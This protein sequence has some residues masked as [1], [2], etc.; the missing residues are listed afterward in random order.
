MNSG[1]LKKRLNKESIMDKPTPEEKCLH[2]GSN[3]GFWFDRSCDAEGNMDGYRCNKCGEIEKPSPSPE[4][5]CEHDDEN[6]SCPK[7]QC[8]DDGIHTKCSCPEARVDW[9]K[10]YKDL[11][12]ELMCELRDPNGTIWEH[13]KRLQDQLEELQENFNVIKCLDTRYKTLE[14]ENSNL[15]SALRPFAERFVHSTK[16]CLSYCDGWKPYKNDKE[17]VDEMRIAHQALSAAFEKG[18]E[19]K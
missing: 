8:V 16:R 9:E 13:A 5:R 12:T 19:A 6:P 3:E 14:S 15:R 4:A 18:R 10:K 1:N 11:N 17:A 7:N 2:C